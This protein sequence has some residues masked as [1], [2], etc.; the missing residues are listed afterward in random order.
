MK[1]PSAVRVSFLKLIHKDHECVI[2]HDVC[3]F[4]DFNLDSETESETTLTT[5]EIGDDAKA[6]DDEEDK[7]REDMYHVV[8][9]SFRQG[10]RRAGDIP[11]QSKP[12]QRTRATANSTG[13]DIAWPTNVV[14]GGYHTY[15]DNTEAYGLMLK[16]SYYQFARIEDVDTAGEAI[17]TALL[18][19]DTEYVT[20]E[21]VT[22][23]SKMPGLLPGLIM[24]TF[25]FSSLV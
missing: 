12:G 5:H 22:K 19:P 10:P 21:S 2:Y 14:A 3:Y 24:L 25:S 7:A 17:P 16:Y 8:G 20:L 4:D 6:L 11:V 1:A 15:D 18:P 23:V 13:D 9:Q